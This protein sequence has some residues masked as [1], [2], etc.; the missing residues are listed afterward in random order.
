MFELVLTDPR[1]FDNER[2]RC[3]GKRLGWN[4][5]KR[6]QIAL[7]DEPKL[8]QD[9]IKDLKPRNVRCFFF[10]D[11]SQ[12]KSLF[13]LLVVGRSIEEYD[14]YEI[15]NPFANKGE[16]F[17]SCFGNVGLDYK[18][19][20]SC[21]SPYFGFRLAEMLS[22]L[23]ADL[24]LVP[25][26]E[27][28]DASYYCFMPGRVT[29]CNLIYGYSFF[30]PGTMDPLSDSSDKTPLVTEMWSWTERDSPR[31]SGVRSVM[32]H[33]I[34]K[35]PSLAFILD[36][37]SF[38]Q[39]STR[40]RF[41]GP[42]SMNL[43]EELARQQKLARLG[44]VFEFEVSE[45]NRVIIEERFVNDTR[46]FSAVGDLVRGTPPFFLEFVDE[47]YVFKFFKDLVSNMR[48][49]D[50]R[51]NVFGLSRVSE[52]VLNCTRNPQ[53]RIEDLMFLKDTRDIKTFYETAMPKFMEK[54]GLN[55]DEYC[56]RHGQDYVFR[57]SSL[58]TGDGVVMSFGKSADPSVNSA[59]ASISIYCFVN[60]V[61]Y[62]INLVYSC[63][64][65]QTTEDYSIPDV[66]PFMDGL[67]SAVPMIF[68][69]WH[70]D[71]VFNREGKI[72]STVDAIIINSR[73]LAREFTDGV[74]AQF[75][76]QSPD[77]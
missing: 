28:L 34:I 57:S 69:L 21:Y 32:H 73:D 47:S 33:C 26:L 51:G 46:S 59:G 58:F 71:G 29:V 5:D 4:I 20:A 67:R 11:A 43:L 2:L 68:E 36:N 56:R 75:L 72:F 30:R 45:D 42:Y 61:M 15:K 9:V 16:F 37:L 8:E 65:M 70:W 50:S 17:K 38:E 55:Y 52:Y 3:L 7:Y 44:E 6:N 40:R 77:P 53:Y 12:V 66:S 74:Y 24:A 39:D 10:N 25:S 63:Q 49:P 18:L 19:F 31:N 54:T 13:K 27:S 41:K 23:D 64:I 48:V 14:G 60:G 76:Q 35:S 1:Q 62:V 22:N